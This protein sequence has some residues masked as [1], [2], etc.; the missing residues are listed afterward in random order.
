MSSMLLLEL[1]IYNLYVIATVT[2]D[3]LAISILLHVV[4]GKLEP[5]RT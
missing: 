3:L 1:Q 4:A 2:R 5:K